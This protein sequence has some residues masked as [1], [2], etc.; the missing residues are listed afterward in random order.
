MDTLPFKV[1]KTRKQYFKYC[2]LVW[3]MLHFEKKT[4]YHEDVIELLTVLIEKWDDDH[5]TFEDLDPVE[6]LVGL[7]DDHKMKSVDLAKMLDVSTSLVSDIL[8]YRR[9]FSKDIVR[10]LAERFK[11]RQDAF[12]RPYRLTGSDAPA[13]KKTVKKT[14]AKKA[15]VKKNPAKTQVRS[16]RKTPAPAIK[17]KQALNTI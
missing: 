10:K 5:N 2:D 9:A 3:E 16:V 4:K 11:M 15:T 1:I 7:M 6:L 8:N 17:V 13:K 14:A 12:N